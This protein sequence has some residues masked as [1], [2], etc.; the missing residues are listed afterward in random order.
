LFESQVPPGFVD[1]YIGPRGKL[2][3]TAANLL[4]SAEQATADQVSFGAL[5]EV[6]VIPEFDEV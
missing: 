2:L 4:P 1:T 6:R 3:A 5:L